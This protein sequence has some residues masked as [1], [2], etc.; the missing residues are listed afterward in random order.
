MAFTAKPNPFSSIVW[1]DRSLE[2]GTSSDPFSRIFS[3]DEGIVQSMMME[4]EPWEDYHHCSHIPDHIEDYS[5]KLNHPSVVDFL[6]NYVFIYILDSEQ[7]L[8][9]IE[10][11]ISINISTKPNVVENIHVGKSRSPLE[12]DIYHA[13]FREFRDIFSWSYEE[14]PVIDSS[15]VE[16]EIKMYLNVK[17]VRQC[18]HPI[19]PKKAAAIKIEVEK[20]L[21][22][23]FIYPVP[24]T[25]WVSNIVLVMKKQGTI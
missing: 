7:N 5:S 24:L 6:S 9:N 4:G 12:L 25:D 10:G 15:I 21:H 19:H 23:G 8:S 22:A 14:M 13:L 1:V 11:T 20:I 16:H 18:L 2:F 17:P 3:I